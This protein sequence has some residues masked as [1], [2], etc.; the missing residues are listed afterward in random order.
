MIKSP[1]ENTDFF[2]AG[3]QIIPVQNG[4]GFGQNSFR[5]DSFPNGVFDGSLSYCRP[6]ADKFFAIKKTIFTK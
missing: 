6:E 3:W 1:V 4:S 5:K 2:L